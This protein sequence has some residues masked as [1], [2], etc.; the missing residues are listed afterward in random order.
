MIEIRG[1]RLNV[2]SKTLYTVV[3]I[4]CVGIVSYWWNPKAPSM[5]PSGDSARSSANTEPDT[6]DN[7]PR[8]TNSAA[9][10]RSVDAE[11]RAGGG[12][13][14]LMALT[15]FQNLL[16]SGDYQAAV[17]AYDR[18]Y[19][20][21]DESISGE[22]REVLL[23]HASN[24]I[25]ER[26]LERSAL[27]LTAYVALYYRDVDA[28][29]LLGE[30]YHQQN[31][32]RAAIR[33]WQEAHMHSHLPAVRERIQKQL[34]ESIRVYRNKLVDEGELD[35]L[36]ALFR[37]L[38][39]RQPNH[40][41]Y[42]LGLANAYVESSDYDQALSALRYIQYDAEIGPRARALISE[43]SDRSGPT[44]ITVPLRQASNT[45]LIEATLNGRDRVALM[46]DTGASMSVIKPAVLARL[47]AAPSNEHPTVRLNTANGTVTARVV[48][49]DSL[50]VG[51]KAVRDITV[52]AVE[53]AE[54]P[55][56]DGLLG[57]DYL[58]HFRFT[59]DQDQ[60]TLILNHR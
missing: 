42:F 53:L 43:I 6:F 60:A 51:D 19:S 58:R 40:S 2:R 1:H 24:L 25:K 34:D 13:Q 39:E 20:A 56:I 11:Q 44:Q 35:E 16:E 3:V 41:R 5:S 50:S 28:L 29:L 14:P 36:V 21:S 4:L 7:D 32:S 46:L 30:A 57:M 31:D 38:I 27:I 12:S 15:A 48:R 55:N 26:N 52:A 37:M 22:Y 47:G 45:Y 9:F 49:L 54:L 10:T 23:Q 33:A 17:Q 18:V 8:G 59:V